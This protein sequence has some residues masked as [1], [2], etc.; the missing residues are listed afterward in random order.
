MTA[1]EVARLIDWLKANGFSDEQA[2]ECIHYIA[3][4]RKN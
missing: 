4:G 2:T 1:V 3:Y